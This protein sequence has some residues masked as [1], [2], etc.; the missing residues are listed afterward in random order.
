MTPTQG[1]PRTRAT[2]RA[3][4]SKTSAAGAPRATSIATCRSAA[5]SVVRSRSRS[6]AALFAVPLKPH[7]L[8]PAGAGPIELRRTD[9]PVS[10]RKE[11]ELG[12]CVEPELAHD[13]SAVRIDRPH[14]DEQLLPDLLIRIA[15]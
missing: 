5:S 11:H 10:E 6:G 14:R 3:T 8:S 1:R 15:E 4:A 9:E 7:G 12:T 2:C 13:V